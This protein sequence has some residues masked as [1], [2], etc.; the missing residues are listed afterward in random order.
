[1]PQLFSLPGADA[2]PGAPAAIALHCSGA[3]GRQW[4]ALAA[5]LGEHYAVLAPD[6]IGSG[7]TPHWSG[8]RPF[9]LAEEARPIIAALSARRA[10]VH[11]VGHSYGGGVALRVAAERPDL[12]ASL[13]LYEPSAFHLLKDSEVG[14]QAALEEIVGVAGDVEW[15]LVTGDYR[16]AAER[17][18]DYWNGDGAWAA[19][20]PELQAG[21]LRYVPKA[22]LDFRALI[23]EP[24]PASA[25]RSFDFPVLL[26]CG[27]E[28][29]APTRMV[30]SGLA[31]MIPSAVRA[32]ID[33]AGHM[34]PV[35]HAET[36]AEA[37]AAHV[38][39]AE[40]RRRRLAA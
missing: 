40:A 5:S 12:V 15:G 29:P 34:G 24:T 35:T 33:G 16:R 14:G 27:S 7:A 8:E 22:A 23:E 11:L 32:V 4:R 31:A 39:R 1:M 25:Y 38:R 26:L 36:V 20:S 18:I 9:S 30:A 17:F 13:T 19:T 6:L 3:T 10:R 21:M 37:M 2:R 28:A